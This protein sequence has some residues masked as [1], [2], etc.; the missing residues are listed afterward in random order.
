[1]GFGT[2]FDMGICQK[3]LVVTV[4][5]LKSC[6]SFKLVLGQL[7]LLLENAVGSS[8]H[9]IFTNLE[10]QSKGKDAQRHLELST[11]YFSPR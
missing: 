1:M 9:Q 3:L 10:F 7:V 4:V 8:R 11:P 2:G 5:A 6:P